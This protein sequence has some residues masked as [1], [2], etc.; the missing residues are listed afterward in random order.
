MWDARG[1]WPA[2]DTDCAGRAVRVGCVG[3][4]AAGGGAARGGHCDA[5][6]HG[7]QS[8]EPSGECAQSN[9]QAGVRLV[10]GQVW[11]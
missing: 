6:E 9:L 8:E 5:R 2:R 4:A 1:E 3:R 11:G 10:W 7:P